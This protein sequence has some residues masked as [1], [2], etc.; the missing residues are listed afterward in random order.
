MRIQDKMQNIEYQFIRTSGPARPIY[1][2]YESHKEYSWNSNKL[3]KLK[4]LDNI[5]ILRSWSVFS[6]KNDLRWNIREEDVRT[7]IGEYLNRFVGRM[8]GTKIICA[9]STWLFN[10]IITWKE[11]FNLGQKYLT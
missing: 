5:L 8:N 6:A 2:P 4:I 3:S 7:E 9:G 10:Q 11:F 1:Q